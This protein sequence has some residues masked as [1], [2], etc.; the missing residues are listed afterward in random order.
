LDSCGI[1]RNYSFFE[2]V[3]ESQVLTNALLA[4]NEGS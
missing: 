3:R 2:G 1:S 4:R